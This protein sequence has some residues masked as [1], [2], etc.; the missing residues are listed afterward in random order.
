MA[1]PVRKI[2]APRQEAP[3]RALL[4]EEP[5]MTL[6]RWV[7]GPDG[8]MKQVD[9]PL[10]PELFLNPHVGDQLSQGQ[11]HFDTVVE[12]FTVLKEHFRDDPDVLIAGDMKHILAPNLPAPGPDISV[13]RGIKIKNDA[14][15]YSFRV[16]REGV[17]PSLII[18]VV[19]PRDP[20]I[21][22]VD[23]EDKVEIYE[24]AGIKEYII[25]DWTMEDLPFRLLG[26]RLDASGH[27]RPIEPDASERLFS[28]TTNL[29]F[30]SSSDGE[31]IFVFTPSRRRFEEQQEAREAAE[32]K[33]AQE[34]EARETAE[35]E[36]ARL[37]AE[38]ERLHGER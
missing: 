29:W 26:Y 38:I 28:E 4:D 6:M 10:T 3:L 17:R 36:I 12:I 37:R 34:A 13:T 35:V 5:G 27:Y 22:Q 25:V 30:Q 31:R 9:M 7:E 20:K 19:C 15:R 1:N 2:R 23:L 11:R 8:E 24:R 14:G 32:Q 33:A 21:R 18:E 16:K